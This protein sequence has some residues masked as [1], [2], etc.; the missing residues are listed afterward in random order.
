MEKKI[1]FKNV[2]S[3]IKGNG[4]YYYDKLFG[5]PKHIK[6][7]VLWRL[8]HCQDCLNNKECLYCGCNPVKKAFLKESC[9]EGKRFP[10][11]MNEK[12]WEQYKIDN[13]I[14]DE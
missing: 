6:E 7:Q 11:L 13:Y 10:E 2:I 12:E 3:F 8:S 5:V 1:T 4:A 9:N 14:S